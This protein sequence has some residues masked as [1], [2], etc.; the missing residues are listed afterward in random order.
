MRKGR[1]A[2]A[3]EGQINGR[4]ILVLKIAC[5][6]KPYRTDLHPAG[7]RLCK[8]LH[9]NTPFLAKES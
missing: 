1:R 3:P 8:A 4:T 5:D 9:Q 7:Y 6:E 2:F